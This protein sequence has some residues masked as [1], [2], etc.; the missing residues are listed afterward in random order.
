MRKTQ[1]QHALDKCKQKLGLD[2]AIA[3]AMGDC[4][5]CT[6][7]EIYDRYGADAK[8]LWLKYFKWGANK[9]P[10][11]KNENYIAHNLTQEQRDVV[12]DI[13]SKYFKVDWDKSDDRAIVIYN[14]EK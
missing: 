4:Q 14:K 8:G 11:N 9:S 12:Y 5:T 1:I 2:Y 10:F 7:A 13:L 3:E 6:W